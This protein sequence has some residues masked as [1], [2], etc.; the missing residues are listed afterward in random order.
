MTSVI[1][2]WRTD[3]SVKETEMVLD[4]IFRWELQIAEG[5]FIGRWMAFPRV[6][7]DLSV[8]GKDE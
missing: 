6:T 1:I 8:G 4:S 5:A 2:I 3:N 7:T